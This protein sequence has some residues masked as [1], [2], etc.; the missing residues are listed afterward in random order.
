M[1]SSCV[2]PIPTVLR[3][4]VTGSTSELKQYALVALSR[5]TA[6]ALPYLSPKVTCA[7]TREVQTNHLVALWLLKFHKAQH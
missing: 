2:V 1:P 6:G 7:S 3:A 4:Y 5:L